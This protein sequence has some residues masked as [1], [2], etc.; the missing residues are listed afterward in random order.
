MQERCFRPGEGDHHGVVVG[1]DH[2]FEQ[3]LERHAFKIRV[4]DTGLVVPRV[5]RVKLA[6]EAPQHIVGVEVAGWLEVVG[7]VELHPLAQVEGVGQPV[8]RDVPAF[9]QG[10]LEVGGAGLEVDQAVEHGF[11]GCIE[12][13]RR[14]VLNNV[15]PFRAGFGAYHQR[16]GRQLRG[17]TQHQCGQGQA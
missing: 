14:G 5:V 7:G 16:F 10:W 3:L 1:L 15:E 6:V 17:A 2:R 8:C 9:G 11:G 4:A 12:G 13:D